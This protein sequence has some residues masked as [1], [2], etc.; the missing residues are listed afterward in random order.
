MNVFIRTAICGLALLL[1]GCSAD[2]TITK[3][4]N[5]ADTNTF[6]PVIEIAD[7]TYVQHHVVDKM[8]ASIR[9]E[10]DKRELL[11]TDE[12]TEHNKIV[13]TITAYSMRNNTARVLAGA[14]AGSDKIITDVSVKNS[15]SNEILAAF[16]IESETGSAWSSEIELI[17]E[18]MEEIVDYLTS[19]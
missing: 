9:K 2:M 11:A 5:R 13:I 7:T 3:E 10:L 18:H 15:M 17:N 19:S 16:S 6:W 1:A 12:S 8:M 4:Y 14:F